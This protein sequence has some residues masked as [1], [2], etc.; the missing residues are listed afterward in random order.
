MKQYHPYHLVDVSPWPILTSI[1]LLLLTS[2]TVM[3]M[4]MYKWGYIILLTGILMTLSILILWWKDVIRESTYEGSH[5]QLVQNGLRLGMILFIISEVF[6]FLAFFWAFFHSALAPTI[7]LGAIW[8]PKGIQTLNP[9][10]VPFLN[11]IILLSSGGTLTWAH[12]ALISGDRR[13]TI[14]GLSLTII[15][16]I[17]FT[18]IQLMEYFEAP[19][20]I[21]D[22]VYG[23]TF[24]GATGLH[25]LH[26]IIGT[27][28]LT[29]CLYRIIN[30]HFTT[31][32]H[33]G[34]TGAIWYWHFVDVV[35]IFL[36]LS[37]YYW[38]S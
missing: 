28:F 16:A 5:T 4:H 38:G 13:N 26:V 15:L 31:T 17:T 1:S 32:H 34:F 21:A 33:F 11:T 14:L 6:F 2:G 18:S 7:E 24:Y 35:W 30:H 20:A 25:G 23:S 22:S 12:H 3:W 29:V 37:I 9:W 36:F 19:F 27:L 8:P 10:D